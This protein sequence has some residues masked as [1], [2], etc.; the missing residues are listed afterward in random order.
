MHYPFSPCNFHPPLLFVCLP[1][2]SVVFRFP[3]TPLHTAAISLIVFIFFVCFDTV[4]C[5]CCAKPPRP[6]FP[7][8]RSHSLSII[9]LALYLPSLRCCFVRFVALD[10][11]NFLWTRCYLITRIVYK[12]NISCRPVLVV[13]CVGWSRKETSRDMHLFEFRTADRDSYIR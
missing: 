11:D 13:Q 7:R 6:Y 1:R 3:F 2:L 8:S 12:E 5:C 4:P 9:P 10:H